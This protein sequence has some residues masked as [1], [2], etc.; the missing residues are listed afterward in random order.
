MRIAVPS[1]DDRGLDSYVSRHFG[2]TPYFTFIDVE[3][4][5]IKGVEAVPVPYREHWPG[6]LPGF[7]K[8]RGADVVLLYGAGRRAL[9]YFQ[10]LGVRVIQ[11]V[12]GRVGDVVKAFLEG[13]LK[14]SED[15]RSGSEFGGGCREEH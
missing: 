9:E 8:S 11:G 7:V 14:G 6:A 15:W 10:E 1:T 5:E 2:H 4:G 12:D 3:D 13:R